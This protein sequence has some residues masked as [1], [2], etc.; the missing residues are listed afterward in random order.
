MTLKYHDNIKKWLQHEEDNSDD[1]LSRVEEPSQIC[2]NIKMNEIHSKHTPTLSPLLTPETPTLM[3]TPQLHPSKSS[4]GP[5]S[6]TSSTTRALIFQVH[7]GSTHPM[8]HPNLRDSRSISP[9]SYRTYVRASIHSNS[10]SG[11]DSSHLLNTSTSGIGL[12]FPQLH[13]SLE[14]PHQG[15]HI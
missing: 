2:H 13:H 8:Q 6:T 10:G 3:L 1:H 14:H 7:M 11:K 9:C 4:Y 5:N 15:H 12:H